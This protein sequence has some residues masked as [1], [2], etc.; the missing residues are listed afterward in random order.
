MSPAL[1][2][3]GME[4]G[5]DPEELRKAYELP[6]ATAGAGA[7]QTVAVVDAFDDPHAASDLATYRSQY[8]IQPCTESGHCF[9]KINQT[10]GTTY[11]SPDR[12][13]AR[14]ISIDLDMV[15]AICPECHIVLVEAKS[16]EAA[17]LATA[18]QEAVAAG[19]TEISDSFT[20]GITETKYAASYHHPGIPIAA[21]AGDDDEGVVLP[22]A[23]PGVIAVGGTELS[24]TSRGGWNEVAWGDSAGGKLSGTG[25]GCSTQPKPAWQSDGGCAGRTMNDV[26]AV[27]DPNTPVSVYDSEETS[28]PWLL[29]GG[30]S[31]STPIVAAAMA[32]SNP[33]TRSYEGAQALY[34]ESAA[35]KGFNDVVSGLD[36]S[37]GNYLCKAGFGYDGPTGLGGL[38]GAPE[39]PPPTPLSDTPAPLATTSATLQATVNPHGASVTECE[40]EYGLTS[41]YGSRAPCSQLPP[42]ATTAVAVSAPVSGLT[43]A[44]VYHVRL[45][46]SYR[47][48]PGGGGTG[49]SAV[50]SDLPFTTAPELPVVAS[51]P[52][53]AL[54]PSSLSLTGTV[55]PQGAPVTLCRFEYGPTSAYGSTAACVPSP[56]SG[57]E[58]VSV[59]ALV[60]GLQPAAGYHYRLTAGNQEGTVHGSDEIATTLPEAPIVLTEPPGGL[61]STSATLQANVELNTATASLCE[62]EF[63][64]AGTDVPCSA[65]P[66]GDA[67][68]A[69]SAVVSGLS[70]ASTYRYRIIAADTGGATYGAIEEFTTPAAAPVTGLPVEPVLEAASAELLGR[71]FV[72]GSTAQVRLRLRCLSRSTSCRG[73]LSL[74]TLGAVASH[75]RL[76]RVL[77]LASS[78]FAVRGGSDGTLVLKLSPAARALLVRGHSIRVHATVLLHLAGGKTHSSQVTVTLRHRS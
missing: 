55:N 36:G 22:A 16:A 77:T 8:G 72:V 42:A 74:R 25:S 5:Y 41:S 44:T 30:T 49:G 75:A 76:K 4:G 19:A 20:E 63:N 40:F 1:S 53:A 45:R 11:P 17:D 48:G 37:C 35:G 54:V 9:K 3:Q 7:G 47:G 31:V 60:N 73:T 64:A 26:A 6:S 50:S 10:G 78:P 12:T 27:A 69:V 43:P 66:A 52:A 29:L 39:V 65:E 62:F 34:L 24:L 21:A 38:R 13:W 18:E 68:T 61:T 2:A 71:T 70:P 56:G 67:S 23:Y 33:Y 58:T 51:G 32:L 28:G 14:E 46:L 59:S 57:R 15:S